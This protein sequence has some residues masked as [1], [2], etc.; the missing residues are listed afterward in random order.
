MGYL[1]DPLVLAA[2]NRDHSYRSFSQAIS[3]S[4]LN[5]LLGSGNAVQKKLVSDK[6]S[7]LVLEKFK[8]LSPE[9]RKNLAEL[10]QQFS[11]DQQDP[12]DLV[13]QQES[14][15]EKIR[16]DPE[17]MRAAEEMRA[18][19]QKQNFVPDALS[20]RAI[21]REL[22][23]EVQERLQREIAQLSSGFQNPS[24]G[25]P[26][27]GGSSPGGF[28]G[29]NSP[30]VNPFSSDPGDEP[31][32]QPSGPGGNSNQP[33]VNNGKSGSRSPFSG[34]NSPQPNSSFSQPPYSQPPLPQ[35]QSPQTP[36]PGQPGN[37]T[38]SNREP[39]PGLSNNP[40]GG[41]SDDGSGQTPSGSTNPGIASASGQNEKPP[42]ESLGH[43]FNRVLLDS[44][45][46]AM[47]EKMGNEGLGSNQSFRSLLS[48]FIDS[49]AGSDVGLDSGWKRSG[50][51]FL[52]N[53]KTGV[54]RAKRR[55]R[56]SGFNINSFGGGA[57]SFGGGIGFSLPA[58]SPRSV[59]LFLMI[60]GAIA[61]LLVFAFRKT[62]FG[63]FLGLQTRTQSRV[64]PPEL[65]PQIH[66]YDEVV[67]LIDRFTL[68]LFGRKASWWNSKIVQREVEQLNPALA[69]EVRAMMRLYDQARYANDNLPVAST[70]FS[71]IKSTLGRLKDLAL[72]S[73]RESGTRLTVPSPHTT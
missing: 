6:I 12:Y 45:G 32:G 66:D 9:Q 21:E 10:A 42:Q 69:T 15:E 68:W 57:S 49:A 43:K 18:E 4:Q 23:Q 24:S 40:F 34:Q 53:I 63:Q 37:G 54:G 56:G 58:I 19:F 29:I 67:Q 27:P 59:V 2:Q 13:Q 65:P 14:L 26:D 62:S 11:R 38:G 72:E 22:R 5:E 30:N 16:S 33:G 25:N 28:S 3:P 39:K 31:P 36:T 20:R 71:R 1:A 46:N 70:E 55:V 50:A 17:L 47:K 60:T 73:N 51:S 35:G 44:V 41:F 7:E 8:E 64:Q 61:G 48:K 52:K